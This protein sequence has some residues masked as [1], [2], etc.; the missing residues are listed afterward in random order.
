MVDM[1]LESSFE[2]MGIDEPVYDFFDTIV[3]GDDAKR[4]KPHPDLYLLAIEK[5]GMT[6]SECI[7]IEDSGVGIRA[8]KSAGCNKNIG[9]ITPYNSEDELGGADKIIYSL[10]DLTEENFWGW[11]DC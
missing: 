2:K 1:V 4:R 6:P 7:S 8:A 11:F 5:L 9:L 3:S 10:E